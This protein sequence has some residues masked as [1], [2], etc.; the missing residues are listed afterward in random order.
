MV[1]HEPSLVMTAKVEGDKLKVAY[2]VTNT[3]ATAICVFD[4]LYD[5][6]AQGLAL[7]WA[8]VELNA[9]AVIASRQ[10]WPLPEGLHHENP[11]VPYART[12]SPG[13]TLKGT[14]SLP[15]PVAESDPYRHIR[16]AG[17]P[18]N[19]FPPPTQLVFRL[20]WA[21]VADL[22]GGSQIEIEDEPL[23]L[24]PYSEAIA[25][26]RLTA[27]PPLKLVAPASVSR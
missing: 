17:K 25:K 2:A 15:L 1:L 3:G 4:R 9:T 23:T 18:A 8:Y 11:E 12:L 19:V 7:D 20:G 22:L 6:K 5:M 16:D 13:A 24:F 21:P 27:T 26:Q 14:L 10:V